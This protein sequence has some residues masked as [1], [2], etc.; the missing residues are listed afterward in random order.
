MT[1]TKL[2]LKVNDKDQ[3]VFM[4]YGLL[5]NVTRLMPDGIQDV[6]TVSQSPEH[7]MALIEICLSEKFPA[8]GEAKMHAE[9]Y[10]ISIE[11]GEALIS[12]ALAHA[13]DFFKKAMTRTLMISGDVAQTLKAATEEGQALLEKAK[14]SIGSEA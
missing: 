4:S 8:E 7:Q 9:D 5:L 2:K 13:T 12:W 3:E 6:A 11:D 14:S 1:E 10:E